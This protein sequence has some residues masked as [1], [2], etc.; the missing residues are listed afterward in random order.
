MKG[1]TA[2]SQRNA[3]QNAL[4]ISQSSTNPYLISLI[5]SMV[6]NDV[7][8][9]KPPKIHIRTFFVPDTEREK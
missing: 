9:I 1:R 2:E 7:R 4:S 3:K 5:K 8:I 6:P